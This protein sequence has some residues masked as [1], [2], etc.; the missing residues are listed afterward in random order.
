LSVKH[1]PSGAKE[2][3]FG[4]YFTQDNSQTNIGAFFTPIT[5]NG[6]SSASY[7][8]C[9][10]PLGKRPGNFFSQKGLYEF[11]V[12]GKVANTR[13]EA[14]KTTLS[15][16]RIEVDPAMLAVMQ[17]Q[18]DGEYIYPLAIQAQP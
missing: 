1:L 15:T 18:P 9:F 6:Y 14:A 2:T 16:F 12:L 10:Y 5:L 8:V 3:Y 11:Q 13:D 17:S 4:Q 7:T